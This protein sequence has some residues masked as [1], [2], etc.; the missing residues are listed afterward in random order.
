[1]KL[2]I[3]RTK[4]LEEAK[5]CKKNKDL[6]EEIVTFVGVF[7]VS[8]LLE[9]LILAVPVLK[10]L[11]GSDEMKEITQQYSQHE[12]EYGEMVSKVT[13]LA[14]NL[15]ASLTALSLFATVMITIT[16]VVYCKFIEKRRISSMGFRKNK[17]VLEYLCGVPVGFVM[18]SAA[19][20]LCLVTGAVE[21]QGFEG[22]ISV[23]M[24]FV[25]LLGFIVQGM[26]EEV[27]CRGYFLVSLSRK[28]SLAAA[29]IISSTAFSLLHLFNSGFSVLPFI[30]IT[31]FGAFAAVYMLKRGNIWGV[32]GIHSI[33]NFVQ[34]NFYGLSVSGMG[35]MD[36]VIRMSPVSEHDV[37]NGGA[38]G[39]E[40]G[41]AVTAVCVIGI[42]IV[43]LMPTKA[44]EALKEE[45]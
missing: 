28:T 18:F 12:I 5:E 3:K 14:A 44:S 23:G 21:Y 22:N 29:V 7:I 42:I 13:A 31:L 1:M 17:A 26:S 25:M 41:L 37:I 45:N 33:W 27:L 38:F 32:C 2:E 11:F 24:L 20:L 39:P 19:V 30:N 6:V 36:T 40:G 10:Y 8:L 34:G 15:P 4:M 43:L 16:A 9:S 35:K